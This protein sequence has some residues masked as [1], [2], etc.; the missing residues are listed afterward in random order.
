MT[1]ERD[2]SNGGLILKLTGSNPNFG[3]PQIS[4]Y[5]ITA[6]GTFVGV[7]LPSRPNNSSTQIFTDAQ[8][9]CNCRLSFGDAFND[10]DMTTVELM[11]L[12]DTGSDNDFFWTGTVT[13]TV[14]Q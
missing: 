10:A 8:R 9:I 14:N 13:S 4:G 6:S 2:G 12:V 7:N 11:R 5:G 3:G 1:L